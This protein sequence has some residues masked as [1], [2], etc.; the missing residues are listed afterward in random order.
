MSLVKTRHVSAVLIAL[1]ASAATFNLPGSVK[2]QSEPKEPVKETPVWLSDLPEQNAVVG[3]GKFG[4]NGWAGFEP[5]IISG[6][7]REP[8]ISGLGNATLDAH[9]EYMLDKKYRLFRATAAMNY[10]TEPELRGARYLPCLG[11]R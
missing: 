2:A 5:I 11:R 10:S 6:L 1:F 7:H 3:Y 4:K 8:R 9:V